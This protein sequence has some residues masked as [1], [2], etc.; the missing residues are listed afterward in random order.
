MK[1]RSF[2]S[3]IR[4]LREEKDQEIASLRSKLSILEGGS[5][6]SE[7][8]YESKIIELKQLTQSL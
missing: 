8:T 4:I 5:R 2:E 6:T 7:S 3:Q 1:V